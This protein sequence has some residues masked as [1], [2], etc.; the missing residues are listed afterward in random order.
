MDPSSFAILMIIAAIVAFGCFHTLQALVFVLYGVSAA[1]SEREGD[2]ENAASAYIARTRYLVGR[3][4]SALANNF[5]RAAWL[6]QKTQNWERALF[7]SERN[8]TIASQQAVKLSAS[9]IA[10]HSAKMLSQREK[11]IVH[12]DRLAEYAL[13][14]GQKDLIN[15]ARSCSAIA[16]AELGQLDEAI[17]GFRL[18]RNDPVYGWGVLINE[19]ECLF[20]QGEFSRAWRVIAEAFAYETENAKFTPSSYSWVMYWKVVLSLYQEQWDM[21]EQLLRDAQA[22]TDSDTRSLAWY[23]AAKALLAAQRQDPDTA[24][25]H[26]DTAL[27][28]LVLHEVSYSVGQEGAVWPPPPRMNQTN[29]QRELLRC[30][31]ALLADALFRLNDPVRAQSLW[32]RCLTLEP[33]PVHLP[34]I[35]FGLGECERILGNETR[36][37][38]WY[39]AAIS[40]KIS[41]HHTALAHERLERLSAVRV[42]SRSAV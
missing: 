1:R 38:E 13:I 28:T 7:W 27:Q 12:F 9:H 31:H 40:L 3:P 41:T 26:T 5:C 37:A 22:R 18:L 29:E 42:A 34:Q 14:S 8:L 32:R 20:L 21:A 24:L 10:A 6:Y 36:A 30:I 23:D 16:L 11:A 4:A 19:A 33:A 35:H 39:H 15:E 17:T 2:L 25:Q